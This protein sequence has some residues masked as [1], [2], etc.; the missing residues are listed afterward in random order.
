MSL[1]SRPV[2]VLVVVVVNTGKDGVD[3]GGSRGAVSPKNSSHRRTQ[4]VILEA[5]GCPS[6]NPN[7]N[8]IPKPREHRFQNTVIRG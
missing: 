6:L 2:G 8:S 4:A 7:L 5:A 3:V 1:L